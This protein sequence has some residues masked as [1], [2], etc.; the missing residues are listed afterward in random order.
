M[1][2]AVDGVVHGKGVA[3]LHFCEP[4]VRWPEATTSTSSRRVPCRRQPGVGQGLAGLAAFMRE[5]LK[6]LGTEIRHGEA[7]QRETS[8]AA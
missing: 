2:I 7:M 3:A 4:E 5:C 6:V 8:L 1:L